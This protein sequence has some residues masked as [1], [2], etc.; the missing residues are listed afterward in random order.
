MAHISLFLI[1]R[2]HHIVTMADDEH[3]QIC[4]DHEIDDNV[5]QHM[6]PTRVIIM[7]VPDPDG[8]IKDDELTRPTSIAR[9]IRS[10]GDAP[11]SREEIARADRM[12]H[13]ITDRGSTVIVDQVSPR[14]RCFMYALVI[15]ARDRT[16]AE[17]I[18][19]RWP[20]ILRGL[21]HATRDLSD[22]IIGLFFL[23]EVQ[24]RRLRRYVHSKFHG[25]NPGQHHFWS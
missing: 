15:S 14:I 17:Y 22:I 10:I 5:T 9:I 12:L 18:D 4:G 13:E 8:D 1:H 16:I 20:V 19:D 23:P 21:N 24:V 25:G 7:D 2:D 3:R 11:M 6:W